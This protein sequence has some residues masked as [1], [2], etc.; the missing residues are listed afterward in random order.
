MRA[1]LR[2]TLAIGLCLVGSCREELSE[3]IPGDSGPPETLRCGAKCVLLASVTPLQAAHL[4][5]DSLSKPL[6]LAEI[7]VT[8]DIGATVT[9]RLTGDP[10]IVRRIASSEGVIVDQ[11]GARQAFTFGELAH[12]TTVYTFQGRERVTLR[13]FL[14]RGAAE[15]IETGRIQLL[16]RLSGPAEITTAQ[17][18][19]IREPQPTLSLAPTGS[20][21]VTAM[22]T[23]ACQ[24]TVT[25]SPYVT[26]GFLG[27]T[28]QSDP[29]SGA[30]H[31]ITV[32][33]ASAVKSVTVKIYDSDYSGN[34]MQA[35]GPG[36][37]Q[38]VSFS[39]DNQPFNDAVNE[40]Q[41]ITA[42]RGGGITRVDLIP[43]P[44]DYVAYDLSWEPI[45]P[46]CPPVGDPVLDDPVNREKFDSSFQASNPGGPQPQRK[47][48]M[49]GGY[50]YPDGHVTSHDLN[51]PSA[52]NCAIPNYAPP[53]RTTDGGVLVW[54]WH[55]HP[56]S[57]AEPVS[58]CGDKVFPEPREYGRGPS[59]EDWE[60]L[61][62]ANRQLAIEGQPPATGY[63]YDR[64]FTYRMDPNSIDQS[65]KDHYVGFTRYSTT[66]EF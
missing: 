25:T 58:Q 20:C 3:P 52:T 43:A 22:I 14:N 29:G 42:P 26:S 23:T 57:P 2:F 8:G 24:N 55:S 35:A 64:I 7:G 45:L 33:F 60:V 61:N 12:G 34:Q 59:R 21:A 13:Y 65:P 49:R 5:A 15:P 56:F 11:A 47:E 37:S 50:K 16:Q 32:T 9:L 1:S 4:S 38:T 46:P 40:V 36:V 44:A 53:T 62:A 51:P 27:A 31:Q 19:W 17:R 18:T 48:H 66:C 39:F 6:P 63:I 10:Q 54:V 30:S 28:F 41:T